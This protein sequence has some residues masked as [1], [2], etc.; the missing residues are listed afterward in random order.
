MSGRKE[1]TVQKYWILLLWLLAGLILVTA[2][3]D[4]SD[5][6]INDNEQV[7]PDQES[8]SSEIVLTK[9]G[10]KRAR[11]LAGHLMKFNNRSV[12]SMD[13][14]I[15]VD[16]YNIQQS[17][18][19]HLQALEAEINE[20]TNDLI[21]RGRVV[22]KSDSGV[23]LYTAE[24]GWDHAQEKIHSEQMVTLITEQDTLRGVGFESDSNLENWIIRQPTGVTK[25]EL[26]KK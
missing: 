21:A 19:S 12:V 4:V 17:H 10:I 15:E 11:I 3:S 7:Y 16:F 8:W 20:K 24:L 5:S 9:D 14:T 13:D 1:I 6:E 23:T 2:C 22:V 26:E 25:R 18:L